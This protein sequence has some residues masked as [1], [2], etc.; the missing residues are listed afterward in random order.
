MP[1]TH[2]PT[3]G[4]VNG[5]MVIICRDDLLKKSRKA[6]AKC[7][8]PAGNSTKQE[9]CLVGRTVRD[10]AGRCPGHHGCHAQPRRRETRVP[11]SPTAGRRPA[12]DDLRDENNGANAPG[13]ADHAC[14]V[15]PLAPRGQG[16]PHPWPPLSPRRPFRD[17]AKFRIALPPHGESAL[18]PARHVGSPGPVRDRRCAS[19]ASRF[20]SGGTG[21]TT[22]DRPGAQRAGPVAFS[23][24]R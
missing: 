7:W 1:P 22:Q 21:E 2:V 8:T 11:A 16:S 5:C 14:P 17:G 6:A 18:R 10:L 3:A 9:L 12:G 4:N 23:G 13:S 20:R 19:A 15:L 24:S